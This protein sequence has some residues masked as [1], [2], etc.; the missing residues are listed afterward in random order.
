MI[1]SFDDAVVLWGLVGSWWQHCDS[2]EGVGYK[3]S[4]EDHLGRS[5]LPVLKSLCIPD[6]TYNPGTYHRG[7]WA[8]RVCLT[9]DL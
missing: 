1:C 4:L 9:L 3:P 2:S 7:I 8:A 6:I 5:W